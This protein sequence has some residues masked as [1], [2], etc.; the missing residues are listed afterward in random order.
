M[1]ELESKET[2]ST[3]AFWIIGAA[4]GLTAAAI[5][6]SRRAKGAPALVDA[7]SVVDWCAKAADR[8]DEILLTS[9]RQAQ[10][11]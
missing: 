7:D 11:A 1:K 10:S 2:R 9:D 3:A 8:L 4:I 6:A 5:L